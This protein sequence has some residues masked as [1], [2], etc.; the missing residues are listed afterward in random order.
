[1][2]ITYLVYQMNLCVFSW[3]LGW[4]D[5]VVWFSFNSAARQTTK[6]HEY[7]NQ[8]TRRPQGGWIKYLLRSKS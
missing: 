2:V 1:M 7:K 3:L 8:T 4:C 6:E 5:F